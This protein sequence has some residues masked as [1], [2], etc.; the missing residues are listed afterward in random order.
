[1]FVK[2]V[3]VKKPCAALAGAVAILL[4][5]IVVIAV[6]IGKAGKPTVYTLKTETQRQDFLK[7]MGWTVSEKYTECKVVTIP[8][9]FNDVYEEYNKLQKKQGFDL[10]KYKGKTVE[11]YTYQVYNYSGHE[12]KDCMIC[13]L[14]ICDG[15]LIG[16][17]VC[18]T[19]LDG[20][21]QGLKNSDAE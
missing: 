16:G 8:E 7:S 13:N 14:M 21:I 12:D 18:C 2:T 4:C 19:E 15:V 9:E 20:F 17:D 5:I 1:M 11:V 3:K 10:E 6:I